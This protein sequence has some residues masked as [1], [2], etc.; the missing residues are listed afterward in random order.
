MQTINDKDQEIA[1]LRAALQRI[2]DNRDNKNWRKPEIC[3]EAKRA[4]S[5]S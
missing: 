4:L 5:R 2:V 3:D 1:R